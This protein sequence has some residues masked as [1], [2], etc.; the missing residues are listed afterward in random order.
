[1]VVVAPGA[2]FFRALVPSTVMVLGGEPVGE[3]YL[4]WNF[5]SSS[6][7]RLEQAAED[8]RAGRMKL[9]DA[10]DA[11]FIPLPAGPIPSAPAM[12]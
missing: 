8:W 6:R 11:E 1:M 5:V 4:Y 12:S 10:D 9:P 7:E 2:S 3:R